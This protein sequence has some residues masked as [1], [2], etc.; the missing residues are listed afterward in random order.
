M[1]TAS[2]KWKQLPEHSVSIKI[3]SGIAQFPSDSMARVVD[4]E[5]TDT[6]QGIPMPQHSS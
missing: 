6:K 3:Y 4:E 1:S 5:N 2:S